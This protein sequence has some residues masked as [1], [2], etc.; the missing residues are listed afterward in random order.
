MTKNLRL[1]LLVA[2]PIMAASVFAFLISSSPR[3]SAAQDAVRE[4]AVCLD[5]HTEAHEALQ[6]TPHWMPS[7]PA[8]GA[9]VSCTDCHGGDSRHWEDDPEAYPMPKLRELPPHILAAR[10][11]QCHLNSHQQNMME[12]NIHA[13]NDVGCLDC[14]AVHEST[15]DGLL[16]T[17]Q[18]ELCTGCHAT[19]KGD[20]A[21]PFRHPVNDEIVR[22][23]DCHATLDVAQNRVSFQGANEA[24]YRCHH[25]FQ[26][27]FPFEHQ[28]TVDYSTDEGGCLNCHDAHGSHTE[29]MLKQPYGPPHF[30]L[31]S[32]CHS[33]PKHNFN[34]RHGDE[35]AGRACNDC[36]VDVHG[37][38]SNQRF[39]DPSLQTQ[40]CFNAG[41]H[42][43]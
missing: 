35:W 10:C 21:K 4:S 8:E 36:H 43:F 14:H 11:S 34:S 17:H 31:C 15:R 2:L 19:T 24:C 28:A 26:G 5:C 12:K 22:C 41:C 40:G 18:F 13:K 7:E 38:Y 27:P 25:Q 23:T 6:G 30:P 37:S 39:L 32:Q 3:D 42:Q 1:F 33:V 9:R 16:K 29:R 20:F